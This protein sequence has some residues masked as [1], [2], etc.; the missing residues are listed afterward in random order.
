MLRMVA[1]YRRPPLLRGGGLGEEG[2]EAVIR[3]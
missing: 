2:R 1:I 3:M